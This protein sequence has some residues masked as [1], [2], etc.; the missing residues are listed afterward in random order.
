MMR[1]GSIEWLADRASRPGV[2]AGPYGYY[3]RDSG[4]NLGIRRSAKAEAKIDAHRLQALL[5][6]KNAK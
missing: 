5:D 2:V 6:R 1:P 4:G 3:G